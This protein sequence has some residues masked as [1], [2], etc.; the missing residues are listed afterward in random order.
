MASSSIP[1]GEREG[2]WLWDRRELS[3]LFAARGLSIMRQGTS[4][5]NVEDAFLQEILANSHDTTPRL[6]YADWLDEHG[7][8]KGQAGPN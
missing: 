8:E 2:K 1:D 3:S 6:I 5:M 7:D 4:T